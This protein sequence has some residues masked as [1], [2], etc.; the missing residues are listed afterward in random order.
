MK[1]RD[2]IGLIGIGTLLGAAGCS[3]SGGSKDGYGVDDVMLDGR[4]ALD[5]KVYYFD[6][7]DY[8][9]HS[10]YHPVLRVHAKKLASSSKSITIEGHAD[11]RGTREYNIGLGERRANAIKRFLIAEG[12]APSQISTISYGEENPADYGHNEA[13]W[14]KNR[15]AVLDY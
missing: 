5:I 15:R 8:T 11:E 1:R 12:V 14:A 10:K 2:L 13:A 3:S 6:F 4:H 7:D 9:I